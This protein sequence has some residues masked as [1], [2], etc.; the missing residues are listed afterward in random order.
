LLATTTAGQTDASGNP[1]LCDIG[2]WLK[3]QLRARFRDSDLKYIDPSY[4]IRSVGSTS[5]D[6]LTCKS[7]AHYAVHAAFAGYT[8]LQTCI[9][10]MRSLSMAA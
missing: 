9:A 6:R 3:A 4:M 1:V 8:G 10:G 7:L 2:A 5:A